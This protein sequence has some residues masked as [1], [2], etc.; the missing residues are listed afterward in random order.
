MTPDRSRQDQ[1]C[2][3]QHQL[4]EAFVDGEL[5]QE[6]ADAVRDHMRRCPGCLAEVRALTE[7]NQRLL[8]SVNERA[9]AGLWETI[10]TQ[11]DAAGGNNPRIGP[12]E[13]ARFSRRSLAA[14]VAGA[15]A[16]AVTGTLI[17]WPGRATVA[18]AA[19]NDFITY[20]A[21][22]W[23]VDLAARDAR[24]L[25]DWAQ[26]RVSFAVPALQERFGG[27]EIGGIRLC[28]LLNRRL[29]G[30]TYSNGD[31]RAVVYIMESR[32]LAIPV[33]DLALPSGRRA[34]VH[35]VNGH[36]VAI[37]SE[38]DL[39]FVLVAAEKDFSRMLPAAGAGLRWTDRN[40]S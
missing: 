31:D 27:F 8:P 35:S 30:L 15:A 20:R 17:V 11:L 12:P 23:T 18:S 37:W 16:A 3:E 2:A 28:W 6:Q 34:S 29:L 19:V 38:N 25:A 10:A 4:L 22:G 14:L 21:K 7:L 33:A 32:D 39:V 9:P 24:A 5:P 26:S 1:L 40:T 13:R 36:G